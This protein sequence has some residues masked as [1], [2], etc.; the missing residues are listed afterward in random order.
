ME[1]LER[2]NIEYLAR[3]GG[4][5]GQVVVVK[6]WWWQWWWSSGGGGGGQVASTL[7]SYSDDPSSNPAEAQSFSLK[8]E[9]KKY[10]NK[11]KQTGKGPL[12]ILNT[13]CGRN[14]NTFLDW[15]TFFADGLQF[16]SDLYVWTKLT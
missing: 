11:Q 9:F 12:K 6:W 1:W 10:K 4:G 5:G 2:C 13:F 3:G 7:A 15:Q 14:D 8:I 16:F